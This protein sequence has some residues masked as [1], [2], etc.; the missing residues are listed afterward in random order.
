MIYL[1]PKTEYLLHHF[2]IH[3]LTGLLGLGGTAG[4]CLLI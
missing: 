3:Y 2:Q 1:Q 4:G